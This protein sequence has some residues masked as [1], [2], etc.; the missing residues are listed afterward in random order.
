MIRFMLGFLLG[1]MCLICMF[2]MNDP[3]TFMALVFTFL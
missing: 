1:F 3:V 2:C